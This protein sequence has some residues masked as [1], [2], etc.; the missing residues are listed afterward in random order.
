ML[1]WQ[2]SVIRLK[3]FEELGLEIQT[4]HWWI[5]IYVSLDF[6][7]EKD[8]DKNILSAPKKIFLVDLERFESFFEI[9]D[10]DAWISEWP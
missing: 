9:H 2:M 4:G 7:W 10:F 5:R 1:G 6:R 3:L 8:T